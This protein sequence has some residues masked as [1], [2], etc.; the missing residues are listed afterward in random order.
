MQRKFGPKVWCDIIVLGKKEE[1]KQ[2][3]EKEDMLAKM[4]K[5]IANFEI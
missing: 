1:V 2:E 3:E 4:Q 5:E